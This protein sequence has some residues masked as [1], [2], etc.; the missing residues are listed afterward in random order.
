MMGDLSELGVELLLDLG[1]IVL[2]SI[3]PVGVIGFSNLSGKGNPLLALV[4]SGVILCSL[5]AFPDTIHLTKDFFKDVTRWLSYSATERQLVG[6][7]LLVGVG[8]G[9]TDFYQG[10]AQ[11]SMAAGVP[12]ASAFIAAMLIGMSVFEKIE[13]RR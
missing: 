8:W 1:L 13:R 7:A 2:G 4:I 3:D 6:G 9:L 5:F 11:V 12:K 10:A